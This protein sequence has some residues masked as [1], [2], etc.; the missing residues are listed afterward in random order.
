MADAEALVMD[1]SYDLPEGSGDKISSEGS[2]NGNE[3]EFGNFRLNSNVLRNPL[4][5]ISSSS[6]LVLNVVE[7]EWSQWSACSVTC[8]R[9]H[10]KRTSYCLDNGRN[11]EEC[12]ESHME[13]SETD[14]CHLRPCPKPGKNNVVSIFLMVILIQCKNRRKLSMLMFISGRFF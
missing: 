8:G 14:V 3:E 6:L 12:I 13:K 7:V 1:A 5:L 10:R 9:G 2:G 11:L 4:F